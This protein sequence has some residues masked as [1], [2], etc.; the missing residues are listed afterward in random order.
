MRPPG[1]GRACAMKEEPPFGCFSRRGNRIYST[2][3]RAMDF[4]VKCLL[5]FLSLFIFERERE[6]ERESEQ[7]RSRERGG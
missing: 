2:E 5:F 6:K 4:Y 3:A 1:L 7:G